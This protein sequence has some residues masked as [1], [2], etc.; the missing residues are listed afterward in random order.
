MWRANAGF[1]LG[2]SFHLGGG[3]EPHGSRGHKAMARL[4]Y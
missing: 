3:G 4:H 1:H 2:I